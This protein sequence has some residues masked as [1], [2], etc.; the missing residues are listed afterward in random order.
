VTKVTIRPAARADLKR[1][2]RH[3]EREWGRGQRTRYLRQLEEH[4]LLLAGNPK[5]G[6]PRDELRE[7]YYSLRAGRHVIFYREKARGIEIV[8]ILH[9]SMDAGRH[10]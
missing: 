5:L 4:I 6:G 10:L 2:G 1:I 8:R 9:A 7:G 3:M